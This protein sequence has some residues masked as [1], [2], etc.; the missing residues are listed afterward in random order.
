[1]TIK[2]QKKRKQTTID[3]FIEGGKS[4]VTFVNSPDMLKNKNGKQNPAKKNKKT[5]STPKN[6]KFVNQHPSEESPGEEGFIPSECS[7]KRPF[8]RRWSYYE[9]QKPRSRIRHDNLAHNLSPIR[10]KK[11][12]TSRPQSKVDLLVNIGKTQPGA[13]LEWRRHYLTFEA[14]KAT[15]NKHVLVSHNFLTKISKNAICKKCH[16]PLKFKLLGRAASKYVVSSCPCKK[17]THQDKPPTISKL[18]SPSGRYIY[19]RDLRLTYTSLL[20]NCGYNGYTGFCC[21]L[22]MNYANETTYYSHVKKI[23]DLQTSTAG[24]KKNKHIK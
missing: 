21:D 16:R 17:L 3:S 10:S 22:D 5:V 20:E 12:I 4:N 8:M 23:F 14:P 19:Q 9:Q 6:Q 18:Q 2:H 13:R 1:M 15:D 11:R 7:P 24:P